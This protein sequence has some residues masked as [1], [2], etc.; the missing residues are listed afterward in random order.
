MKHHFTNYLNGKGIKIPSPVVSLLSRVSLCLPP[1][2]GPHIS[3][4]P[5]TYHRR[6]SPTRSRL[7]ADSVVAIASRVRLDE[8]K[9]SPYPPFPFP[10]RVRPYLQGTD[11]E[12]S[13]VRAYL[14]KPKPRFSW[15][16]SSC[17][18]LDLSLLCLYIYIDHPRLPLPITTLAPSLQPR[19]ITALLLVFLK[20]KFATEHRKIVAFDVRTQ[21]S[22]IC[23]WT[24]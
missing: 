18:E 3:R 24:P 10:P 4:S 11:A 21:W 15:C 13:L 9:S 22:C 17:V 6:P 19:R 1:T 5:S 20:A 7:P 14:P 2:C 8:E 23:S 12:S 16:H